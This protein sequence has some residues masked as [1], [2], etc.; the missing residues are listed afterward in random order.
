MVYGAINVRTFLAVSHPVG[1]G[2]L[3]VEAWIPERA[4]AESVK[5]F[6][7]GHYR[8]LI[9]VGGPIARSEEYSEE[10]RSFAEQAGMRLKKHGLDP[11]KL[12]ELQ[13]AHEPM[14]Y[15]TE[16][17]AAAVAEW[18]GKPGNSVCCVDVFTLGTHA[19]KSWVFFRDQLGDHYRVGII[20]GSEPLYQR[21]RFGFVSVRAARHLLTNVVGY[22][23]AKIWVIFHPPVAMWRW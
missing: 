4:L 14:G 19:R 9:A 22:V 20:S 17:T 8:Y 6:N 16:S 2:V 18:L 1:E 12:V 15:R 10:P 13:V 11:A 7:S 23:Y 21:Q 5:V 3:V